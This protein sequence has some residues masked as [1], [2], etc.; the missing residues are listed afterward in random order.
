[1]NVYK[2]SLVAVM[3]LCMGMAGI[4]L[5][6]DG[7]VYLF[8]LG[9]AICVAFLVQAIRSLQRQVDELKTNSKPRD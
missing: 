9:Q 4:E 3:G 1:M 2:M 6:L 5:L 8:V 7:N